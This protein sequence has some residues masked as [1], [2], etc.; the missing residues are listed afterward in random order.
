MKQGGPEV[1]QN[2]K[3][4]KRTLFLCYPDEDVLE[5]EDGEE[6]DAPPQSLGAACL[7]YFQGD[8]VIHVGELFSDASLSMEQAPWGRSSSPDFQQ[9]LASDFHCLL[10]MRLPN[11]VHTRDSLS[12][13]RRSK[14]C[15]IVFAADEDDDEDE[16]YHYRHV[17]PEE[18]LPV[19]RVA[20][21]L[22]HLL[23]EDFKETNAVPVKQNIQSSKESGN[24]KQQETVDDTKSAF[25]SPW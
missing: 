18:Q 16:E 20:P 13:W 14:T 3:Y 21:C 17:P 25:S 6:D 9:L 5:T 11:W 10:H 4:A 24:A 12:V 8:T 1:L 2:P 19:D 23:K 7:E 15:S 22:A